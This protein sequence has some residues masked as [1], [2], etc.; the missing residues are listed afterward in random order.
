MCIKIAVQS[1]SSQAILHT[2]ATISGH[3][4]RPCSLSTWI[5]IVSIKTSIHSRLLLH[6]SLAPSSVN[7][8]FA[9]ASPKACSFYSP[10][11][12]ALHPRD[13]SHIHHLQYHIE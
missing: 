11:Q 7:D 8:P 1:L 6:G 5:L 4:N 10:A 13:R 2:Q 9:T 12:T 3:K